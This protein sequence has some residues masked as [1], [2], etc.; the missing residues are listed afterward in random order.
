VPLTVVG[1]TVGVLLGLAEG[2]L[3]PPQA[4]NNPR[5]IAT[6]SN[7]ENPALARREFGREASREP[8]AWF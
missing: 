2:L 7:T 1:G 3:E 6:T 4:D 8:S 5:H